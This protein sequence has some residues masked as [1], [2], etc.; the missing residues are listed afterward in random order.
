MATRDKNS[1]DALAAEIQDQILAASDRTVPTLRQ[2]RRAATR[3]V[4]ALE[5]ADVIRLADLLLSTTGVPQWFVYEL[6]HHHRG[7]L[8]NLT[9]SQL[10]RFGRGLAGW[11]EVDPFACYLTGPAWRE[12]RIGDAVVHRWAKSSDRWW[13][14]TA[15]VST[16]PLNSTARGGRGDVARTLAVCEVIKT[17]A[18]DMVVKALS[19]ALRELARKEPEAVRAFLE[20][21]RDCLAARVLR[22]VRNKL[23]TGLKNPPG[24]RRT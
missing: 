6:V 5:P 17:D 1:I 13:R 14:R 22:E 24:A 2:V 9:E 3:R 15:V 10:K 12:G 23:D 4:K 16:V 20:A 8:A 19:W 21:N 11:D 18:D 7:A